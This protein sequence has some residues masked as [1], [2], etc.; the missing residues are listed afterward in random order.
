M[1]LRGSDNLIV[2][3]PLTRDDNGVVISRF[4]YR[5]SYGGG[6]IHLNHRWGDTG[7]ENIIKYRLRVLV[8]GIIGGNNNPI[9]EGCGYSPHL[10]TLPPVPIPT[11]PE[12]TP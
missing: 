9:S 5:L 12:H 11:A 7:G 1:Y 2:L 4:G 6:P 8:P 3:M 10:G